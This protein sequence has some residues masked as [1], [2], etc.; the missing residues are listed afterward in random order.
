LLAHG[1][2]SAA[3]TKKVLDQW[4]AEKIFAT[5]EKLHPKF[6]PEPVFLHPVPSYENPFPKK[7]LVSVYNKCGARLHRGGLGALFT[8]PKSFAIDW[9]DVKDIVDRIYRLLHLHSI[10]TIDEEVRY[11]VTLYRVGTGNVGMATLAKPVQGQPTLPW[12]DTGALHRYFMGTRPT[13]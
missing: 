11:I 1:D 3:A 6:Y 8:K 10:T 9:T 7:K 4:N 13:R 2:I 5:L 12:W